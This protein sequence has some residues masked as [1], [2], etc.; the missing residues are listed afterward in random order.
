MT[1]P[2]K[3][4]IARYRALT[5]TVSPT[6]VCSTARDSEGHYPLYKYN[7]TNGT[8]HVVHPP[9]TL[10]LLNPSTLSRFPLTSL[11]PTQGARV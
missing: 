2:G 5:P 10:T 6:G 3:D 9:F 7:A 8:T 1:P 11:S 4:F